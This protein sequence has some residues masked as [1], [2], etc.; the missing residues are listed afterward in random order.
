MNNRYVS[1]KTVEKLN[2]I[3]SKKKNATINIIN[4]KLTLS[5]FSFLENNLKN[6]KEINFILKKSNNL[7]D[8]R[9]T[10]EFE[11]DSINANNVLFNEYDIIQKSNLNHFS[12]AKQMY[13]FIDKNVNIKKSNINIPSNL[14]IIDDDYMLIGSSSLEIDER[15]NKRNKV[16]N[17]DVSLSENDNK[18]QIINAKDKF[19][20]LWYSSDHTV[21][22]KTEVLKMLNGVFK[23]N[24][25][26]FLYYFT[27]NE[28]FGHTFDETIEKFE[29]DNTKFKQTEI[30]NKLYGFQ[31]DAV[32]SAIQKLEKNNGCIIADSVG[33]GK[34]FEALA[35]IKYYE[36]RNDSVLVLC[37]AKLSDNWHEFTQSYSDSM[38]KEPFN[39][40]LLFHTDLSRYSGYSRYGSDLSRFDWSRYDLIVIDE[41]HNFRNRINKEDSETRYD[42]LINEVI[43][44]GVNTKV[45][46]LSATPVNNSLID[47]K[48]QISLITKDNDEYFSDKGI[49]SISNV[50]KNTASVIT[51]WSKTNTEKKETLFDNLPSSFF[52]LLEMLTISRS[53][54]HI[55]EQ[56]KDDGIGTF[57]KRNKPINLVQEIDTQKE[58]LIF[59]DTFDVLTT[60]NL[61]VYTPMKFILDEHKN[62]YSKKFATTRNGKIVFKQENREDSIKQLH[63][64]NLFKRLESSVFS[65]GETIK[66]LLD[67][68]DSFILSLEDNTNIEDIEDTNLEDEMLNYKLEINVS[69]INKSVYLREL[70]HDKAIME[71]LKLQI[72]EVINENRDNKL[73]ILRETIIDKINITPYNKNNK[74]IIV[75][76]AF[77]DTA[78]YIYETLNDELKDLGVHSA[79]VT[80]SSRPRTTNYKV[81]PYFSNVLRAFSPISSGITT[82]ESYIDILIATDCISE[83]Q[84][85]QDCDTVIN[86]DIHWNPVR[87]IQRF[88]RIDRIGSKNTNI[89]MINFFPDIELNEYLNLEKRIKS[90]LLQVNIASTGD[91]N[92]L[93]PELNDSRFRTR[94]LEKLKSEVIELEETDNNISLTDLNMNEYL[95]ELVHYLKKHDEIK[96]TPR[97]IYSVVVNKDIQEGVIFC[98]KHKNTENK[99]K[100]DSSLYPFYLMYVSSAGEVIYGNKHSRALLKL[101]RNKTILKDSP[102]S[103]GVMRFLK[104][105]NDTN[106]MKDISKLL[107]IA[108]DNIQ[109]QENDNEIESMFDFSGYDPHFA[110]ETKDDFELVDFFV[111]YRGM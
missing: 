71:E 41:S 65:F 11:I 15:V 13:Q 10:R 70:Y 107:N 83:G 106:N 54:K 67:K 16:I 93:S 36:L 66:R 100:S 25:P 35:V 57:P 51:T 111:L 52:K 88:G 53:R 74:K 63:T 19:N 84:N 80:G 34:T 75:F 46:L 81:E 20:S 32:L 43:K 5:V 89:Q 42:R 24:S 44:K 14:V 101:L 39:Y 23:E 62:Y 59:K 90:K 30:W 105:T 2:S 85:L 82:E 77:A 61:S 103:I 40:R 104:E 6:V 108:I 55:L 60:L 79:L 95:S 45:L 72:D 28:L 9:D 31:K 12:K 37:P 22:Y 94:Q 87:L 64:F 110:N 8:K 68:V 56:Y 29:K 86:F 18:E 49:E 1:N 27:L 33:L 98:F 58:K 48:N 78:K 4:D 26:E 97:G 21:D 109:K 17:F 102:N 3:L 91:E 50:L 96:K 7:S 69:H 99:P 73:K 76:T 47:L 92:I 38:F